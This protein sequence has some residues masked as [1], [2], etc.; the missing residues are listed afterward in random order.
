MDLEIDRKP[1][2]FF[3]RFSVEMGLKNDMSSGILYM[4]QLGYVRLKDTIKFGVSIIKP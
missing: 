3:E 1:M 2:H 4:Q